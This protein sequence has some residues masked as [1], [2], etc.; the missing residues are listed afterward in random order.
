MASKI[1]NAEGLMMGE[2]EGM[3]TKRL[4]AAHECSGKLED[5]F[6]SLAFLFL[7]ITVIYLRKTCHNL[8]GRV[9]V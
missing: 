3:E 1:D 6:S 8:N 9:S 4:D 2:L 7:F 5:R